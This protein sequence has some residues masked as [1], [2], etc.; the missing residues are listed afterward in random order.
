M[1]NVLMPII[2]LIIAVLPIVMLC[3]LAKKVNLPKPERTKQFPMPIVAIIY[4]IVAMI[5][6]DKICQ[7][8]LTLIGGLPG[9]IMSLIPLL[10]L[11]GKLSSAFSGAGSLL[12]SILSSLNL[13]LWVFFIANAV[14]MLAFVSLK[15]IIIQICKK[16]VNPESELHEKVSGIFYEFFTERGCWC[17][18]ERFV[19]ARNM[20]KTFYF[21][22]VIISS[23]LMIV[24]R[25]LY[26]S[27]M[28]KSVFFPVFGIIIL[29]EIYFYLDGSS[30]REYSSLLGEDEDAYKVV[31]YSL[32]R[33]FLRTIFKDKLLAENTSVNNAFSYDLSTDEI[34]RQ[35][36]ND[37]DPKIVSFATYMDALNNTGFEIDHNYL[38]SAV[39]LLKGKSILFN[40]P[41]YNDLIPYAFYPMNRVLTSHK[42]VLVVLGR[43]A[44]E[45][46]IREWLENGIEAVTNIPFMWN[47]EKLDKTTKKPDIGVISYSDVLNINVHDANADFLKDVE[48]CVI[49][50]PSKLITTAQI[51]LSLLAKKCKNNE[52]KNVV[53]CICDKNC[54]GLVDTMSHILMTSLSEVS[55]TNKHTGTSS[56][57]SWNSDDDYWQHRLVPNISRYLG[58]G[59]E[60]SFAALKN[61]VSKVQWYGG[62]TFPV[63]DINWIDKQYYFDLMNYAGLPTGQEV[64]DEYFVT[65][66]NFWSAKVENNNYFTVEDEFCNMFEILRDFSTRSKEQGFINVISSEYLLKDYMAENASIFETDAKAIPHIV[67]DYARTDR[68]MFLKLALM[69]SIQKIKEDQLIKEFSLMGIEVFDLK[70]QIWYELYKCYA[71][72]KSISTLPSGY[73]DAVNEAYERTVDVGVENPVKFTHSIINVTERYNIETFEYDKFYSIDDRDFLDKCVSE[74]KSAAYVAEDEQGEKYYLG[75]ELIGQIYQ[76]HIPGQFFTFG[77]KYYEM[78]H[79]TADGQVLVRRAADHIVGRPSYRQK[80]EYIIY[81]TNAVEKVGAQQ[82]ISGMRISRE[83]ADVRVKTSGYLNMKQYNNFASAEDV[84]FE[85][86]YSQIPDRL[87]RNK[88]ILRIELPDADGAFTDDVRYTVTMLLNEVFRTLF[89]ENQAYICAVTCDDHI[90]EGGFRPT[91]Y[92]LSGDGYELSH[93][94]IYIIEDSQLDLG[95]TIAVERNLKRILRIVQDYLEWHLEA[96]EH[97]LNPPK[98][99]EPPKYTGQ[100][101]LPEDKKA[102]QNGI[103]GFVQK[104]KDK[105]KRTLD[106]KDKTEDKDKKDKK[107][108]KKWGKKDKEKNSEEEIDPIKDDP[109]PEGEDISSN[110]DPSL[111]DPAVDTDET[112]NIDSEEADITE[113]T[114][115]EEQTEEEIDSTEEVSDEEIESEEPVTNEESEENQEEAVDSDEDISEDNVDGIENLS[116]TEEQTDEKSSVVEELSSEGDVDEE[117]STEEVDG[118]TEVEPETV[119]QENK[120]NAPAEIEDPEKTDDTDENGET[121]K[122]DKAEDT[123]ETPIVFER[124]PYHERYYTLFGFETEPT[125]LNIRA[126]YEYLTKIGYNNNNEL[127]SARNGIHLAETLESYDPDKKDSRYCDFCGKEIFGVEYE[128]LTDG[129]D[130]CVQCGKTAVKTEADFRKIYEDVKRNMETF[131]SIRINAGIRVEMVNSRRLHKALKKKFVPTN[132]ADGRIIGVAIKDRNGY[133]LM[134]E[135]GAPRMASML[136]IAHELT[137]IWQYLN[138]NK[139]AIEKKYGD[140]TLQVYEGMAKWVEVQYAYLINESTMAR[141]EEIITSLRQDQYGEGFVRYRANYP[142]SRGATIKGR[143]PFMDTETPL[144]MDFCGELVVPI[145]PISGIITPEGKKGNQKGIDIEKRTWDDGVDPLDGPRY[146][147]PEEVRLY[148]FELLSDEEKLVYNAIYQAVMNFEPTV[149]NLPAAIQKEQLAKITDYI[150]RDNPY[151]D[152]FKN[153]YSYFSD[154]ATGVVTKVNLGYCLT[155]EEVEVRQ[156][157]IDAALKPFLDTIES[158]MSDYEVVLRAYNYIIE[159]VDYDSIGLDIQKNDEN[160]DDKPDDLRSVYGVFVNRKTV[161]AGYS[162]ALQYLLNLLGI[163]CTY[164]RGMTGPDFTGYHGWNMLK[165]EGDYYFMDVTW[166]D[167]SN[168]K[169]EKNFSDK[170]NYD[171]F[172]ITSE[173]LSKDHRIE[174]D[175]P[176]PECTATKCNYYHRHGLYFESYDFEAIR[177]TICREINNGSTDVNLKF[178]DLSLR[179]EV[180]KSLCTD[181]KI[182]DIIRY[183]NLKSDVRINT[184]YRSLADKIFPTLKF[185]FEKAK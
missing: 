115:D 143:T 69:L 19:Q 65:S 136:T 101:E 26:L 41:F 39:D 98:D 43:H 178:V 90:D 177:D 1:I 116:D 148:A 134:I 113:E 10:G 14:I 185:Y 77:G 5:F 21:A 71:D 108:K 104:I 157:A 64:M 85:G 153:G 97:S 27:H 138:W 110:G 48:F 54:D 164:V 118:D 121:D 55:A 4:V 79:L 24:S 86:E 18:Q 155:P 50:E 11:V 68:N 2:K 154:T 142:L 8:L 63:V 149:E 105:I 152:W 181:G 17:L 100:T 13:E 126:T 46:D 67:A 109:T 146:R 72:L 123:E 173:E 83:Y 40:N 29:G 37:E 183:S 156:Q 94:S 147:N 180:K 114:S 135:N 119:V 179:D 7:G 23:V 57:M 167:G 176:V 107:D 132:N 30:K 168:T 6:M 140:Y 165:L 160:A 47:I 144:D 56:Y 170:I 128:T 20:L 150:R 59:T 58:I 62:D 122:Q 106:K 127:K 125:A 184:S 12:S 139:K 38:N 161:C 25:Y 15:K 80:R 166:G 89:A 111:E 84:V 9:K 52:D 130:R 49:I 51:G 131:F 112:E 78:L 174:E 70:K 159:L 88:E 99:P 158:R 34:L 137:H 42:K 74:L 28:I 31:N 16:S 73:V 169:A 182:F 32:L 103:K 35:M 95:L 36:E 102:K 145:D 61:Q 44:I 33:K 76:R 162:V 60:L 120:D 117:V 93:N 92:K 141:R 172:C 171:Y 129:R 163:E 75:A 133:R 96:M 53:F 45:D 124:K 3:L 22:A 87:Y 81:G 66:S 151:I 175:L 82:N 91:T